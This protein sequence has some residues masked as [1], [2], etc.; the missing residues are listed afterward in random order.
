MN[1]DKVTPAQ[2][3]AF[4]ESLDA[5]EQRVLCNIDAREHNPELVAKLATAGML[6]WVDRSVSS[7]P[8]GALEGEGSS[9]EDSAART[10]LLGLAREL[11]QILDQHCA[12]AQ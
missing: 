6:F 8:V 3:K 10:P 7:R 5:N 11:V 9:P 4:W 1:N 12:E 2:A